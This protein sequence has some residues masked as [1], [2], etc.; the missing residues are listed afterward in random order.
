[1]RR[2]NRKRSVETTGSVGDWWH[3][4]GLSSH[5]GPHVQTL[6]PITSRQE[7]QILKREEQ[8]WR[9]QWHAMFAPMTWMLLPRPFCT[10]MSSPHYDTIQRGD[11]SQRQR[12]NACAYTHKRPLML[13]Y[14]SLWSF[15]RWNPNIARSVYFKLPALDLPA[16]LHVTIH[17]LTS[18][19]TANCIFGRSWP[20]RVWLGNNLHRYQWICSTCALLKYGGLREIWQVIQIK[21]GWR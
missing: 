15:S 21:G 20:Q 18:Y 2:H 12:W 1:M 16:W 14:V 13:W 19:S 8:V 5:Y 4:D 9:W 7:R 11:Y 17:T 3:A 10:R 6:A